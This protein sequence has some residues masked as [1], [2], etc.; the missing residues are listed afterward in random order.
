MRKIVAQEWIKIIKSDRAGGVSEGAFHSLNLALHTGDEPLRV[1]KNREIF[2]SYF[3][4]SAKELCFMEQIHSS[5]VVVARKGETPKADALITQEKNLILCVMVADCVPVILYD[6]DKKAVAAIH[7]GRKGIFTDII[8]NACEAMRTEF[9]TKALNAYIGASIRSCCYE[10]Q[11]EVLSEA[12]KRFAYAL[13][14]IDGRYFLSLQT[15]I[16]KQLYENGIVN[17]ADGGICSCCD[18]NYFSYRRD[19]VCGRFAVGVKMI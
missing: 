13:K 17:I 12:M 3:G 14:S 18:K 1:N 16:K 8:T 4:V 7:A 10:I 15:I 6:N 2:A 11:G 9:G 5:S 19:G